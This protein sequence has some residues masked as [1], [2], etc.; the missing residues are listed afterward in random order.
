M[1]AQATEASSMRI[2]YL[3]PEMPALSATFVYEE[4][5]ALERR[6]IQVVPFSVHRPVSPAPGQEALS[7]RVRILYQGNPLLLLSATLRALPRFGSGSIR[8][9]AWVLG[10]MLRVRPWRIQAW[11][12]LYQWLAAAKLARQLQEQG[13][14]H[15]H[16]HFAHVPAQIAMYAAAFTGLPFTIM[17]HAN[18]IFE[19]GLLL[20]QKAR[21]ATMM[22]TI[23][24][25][26]V[27]HLR[28]IGVPPDKLAVVR[29]GVS[30]APST[31]LRAIEPRDRYRIGTLG[32][33]VEKKGVDDLLR[34][35]AMLRAAPWQWQLSIAGDG[36]QR[37][38][39]EALAT[40]L[41][42]RDQV[43]FEGAMSHEAV[44]VWMRSLDAFALAC[45]AD[46]RGDMDGIPVV[47][48][49]AMSQRVPVVSTRLSGIPELVIHEKTGL[50]ANPADPAA[51]ASELR[52]LFESAS[53]RAS[54]SEAALRH[55]AA[56]FGQEINLDRLLKYIVPV[57]HTAD[58]S[59]ALASNSP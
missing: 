33:L 56:E 8:A 36:P 24:Q 30:L 52:R 16:V 34:A 25:H 20:P 4:L 53:L 48:M 9:A 31:D 46:A 59:S 38:A 29:C 2:A 44:A 5:L 1:S 32:R 45:K 49:E 3:A 28:S 10:D 41:G 18:D 39:L 54:L 50:L 27:E 47:L 55:V 26:N 12:L 51:L 40:E 57:A 23:S 7:S 19:R 14:T 6:G 42:I 35:L 58:S 37:A 21:R 15:L 43:S 11:K 17:A 22:L 13:C